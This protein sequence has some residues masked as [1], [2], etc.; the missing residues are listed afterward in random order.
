M[1]R[2]CISGLICCALLLAAPA[3][4]ASKS[5]R[6]A[7]KDVGLASCTRYSEEHKKKSKRYFQFVGWMMGYISSHNM[8]TKDNVDVAPWQTTH[9]LAE[10]IASFCHANPKTQLVAA[11]NLL[12]ANLA[13]SRLRTGSK[14]VKITV[15]DKTMYMYEAI[16]RRAQQMLAERGH[17][18]GPADGNFGAATRQAF[19]KFQKENKIAV[20]GMP[21]QR[22]LLLIFR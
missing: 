11:V 15:G 12:I 3:G 7:I 18:N 9:L 22:S 5:G 6:F 20:T 2:L 21:D 14:R 13:S 17:Y 19:E 8:Y 4:A 16:L 1:L 10:L